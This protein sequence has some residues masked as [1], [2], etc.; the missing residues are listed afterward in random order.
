MFSD[1]IGLKEKIPIVELLLLSLRAISPCPDG[2]LIP[3]VSTL[4]SIDCAFGA[5]NSES[6]TLSLDDCCIAERFMDCE[7]DLRKP[8]LVGS[9]TRWK[10]MDECN[11]NNVSSS[12]LQL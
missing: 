10:G 2:R 6:G 3:A 4:V 8:M 11:S 9:G 7:R 1:P 5:A 12:F